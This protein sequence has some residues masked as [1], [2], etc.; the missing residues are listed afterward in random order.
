MAEPVTGEYSSRVVG[1]SRE[2]PEAGTPRPAALTVLPPLAA[3]WS[4]MDRRAEYEALIKDLTLEADARP[5]AYRLDVA[6]IGLFGYAFLFL[7]VVLVAGATLI[8]LYAM[9]HLRIGWWVAPQLVWAILLV[10]FVVIR[11]LG[12]KLREPEGIT[13]TPQEAPRLFEMLE[14]LRSRLGAPP[15][16]R[17]LV[18]DRFNTSIAQIPRLGIFGWHR[19]YLI[20]GLPMMMGLSSDAFRSV[21]AHEFGHL[22]GSHGAYGAW[23]YRTRRTWA[24]VLEGLEE[25]NASLD[26]G[27]RSFFRWYASYFDAFSFVL[28]RAQEYTADRCAAEVTSSAAT[29]ETLAEIEVMGALYNEQLLPLLNEGSMHEAEPPRDA[30][31]RIRDGIVAGPSIRH[32]RW[33]ML[34]ALRNE[35]GIADTHP[36]LKDRLAAIE[37][38]SLERVTPALDWRAPL[39]SVADSAAGRYLGDRLEDLLEQF[40]RTW[41]ETVESA[42][43]DS[44]RTARKAREDLDGLDER[45]RRGELSA[46]E[47][48]KRTTDTVQLRPPCDGIAAL[49][50]FIEAHPEANVARFQL[51]KLLL[52]QGDA[53]GVQEIERLMLE[54]PK[55]VPPGLERIERYYVL[56]ETDEAYGVWRRHA[57][58]VLER[59]I[60]GIRERHE[61]GPDDRFVPYG[62]P[63]AFRVALV[64]ELS[65]LRVQRALVARKVLTQY[66]DMLLLV[67]GISLRST[68]S[69]EED[70]K[71]EGAVCDCLRDLFSEDGELLVF[72][73]EDGPEVTALLEAVE[74]AEIYRK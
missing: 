67:L 63:D 13:L 9:V 34:S 28:G 26:F 20:M 1:D 32:A 60:A 44:F 43:E 11:A 58:E 37:P 42:W 10:G 29:C 69:L 55:A 71:R 39:S 31:H 61:V 51:G 25:Q 47:E 46:D 7:V 62:L 22:S 5:F 40:D 30:F 53:T 41:F 50:E 27:L 48:W 64:K 15:L 14:D 23:I 18:D 17:V 68:E 35:T 70:R 8:V 66:P 36:A 3:P 52:L 12:V 33:T 38:A 73:L 56:H 72:A 45:W 19:N 59:C 54:N 16:H 49:R 57:K 6:L 2:A 21:I 74:G 4:R 24:Q 65:I